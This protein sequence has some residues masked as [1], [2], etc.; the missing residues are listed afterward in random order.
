MRPLGCV[1]QRYMRGES[2]RDPSIAT[3]D[4]TNSLRALHVLHGDV[5]GSHKKNNTHNM[6][7]WQGRSKEMRKLHINTSKTT[8]CPFATV[9]TENK[10]SVVARKR[11]PA[12]RREQDLCGWIPQ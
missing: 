8:F 12:T 3:V 7:L 9:K 10:V 5:R 1:L 2:A 4:V 11:M 6:I